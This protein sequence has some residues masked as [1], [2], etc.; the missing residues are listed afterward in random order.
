[1]SQNYRVSLSAIETRQKKE[2]LSV[3]LDFS[4][5]QINLARKRF[6]RLAITE[7]VLRNCIG[8]LKNRFLRNVYRIK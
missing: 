7:L 3:A 2:Y 1:M 6:F 4:I 5:S 8:E